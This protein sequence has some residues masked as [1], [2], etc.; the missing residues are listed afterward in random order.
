M[1]VAL[2]CRRG[3]EGL[4]LA[5]RIAAT[6]PLAALIL[7]SGRSARRRKLARLRRKL[8]WWQVPRAA[9]DL[10][11]LALYGRW[12]GAHTRRFVRRALDTGE[13]PAAGERLAVDDVNEPACRALLERLRPEVL[14]VY[15]TSLL[16]APLI[17]ALEGLILNIHTGIVPAYRNVHSE[18]WAYLRG[19][20]G[21]IGVSI[22]HLDESVDG[23]AV[24]AQRV[25]ALRG[26]ESLAAIRCAN[27]A[28]AGDLICELL[29]RD[30]AALERHPQGGE[31]GFHPTPGAAELLAVLRRSLGARR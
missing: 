15:G 12:Q 14:V 9:A 8:R 16:R 1:R 5:H 20:L 24:A 27:L 29:G 17:A 30:P 18:L 21:R 22:L 11:A 6:V 23:G 4:Y 13:Y 3:W 19:D 7:E 28:L 10:L 31:V 26:D 25:L 2:A